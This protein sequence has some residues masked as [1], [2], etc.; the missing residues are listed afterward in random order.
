MLDVPAEPMR[1]RDGELVPNAAMFK[2]PYEKGLDAVGQFHDRLLNFGTYF[3]IIDHGMPAT[4]VT[5]EQTGSTQVPSDPDLVGLFP[6]TD[7]F[8]VVRRVGTDGN[9]RQTN[10]QIIAWLRRLNE[11]QPFAII[12][13]GFDFVQGV[14][15]D[16]LKDPKAVAHLYYSFCPD[17]WNAGPAMLEKGPPE[18]LLAKHLADERTFYCWWD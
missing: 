11:T 10:A 7:Q 12:G 13:A 8:D 18:D 4:T 15:F 3:L 2:L 9:G 1:L 16:P 14:F 5:S 6:T 17:A